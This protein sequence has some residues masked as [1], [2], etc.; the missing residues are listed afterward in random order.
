MNWISIT[1]ATAVTG[2]TERTIRRWFKSHKNDH[3]ATKKI[4]GKI[5]L[6][7]TI[8]HADYPPVMGR[9]NA[10]EEEK[11]QKE[12]LQIATNAKSIESIT[13]QLEAKDKQIDRLISHRNW[14]ILV[15]FSIFFFAALL[16]GIGVFMIFKGYKTELE[17]TKER[18]L[19][20]KS[21]AFENKISGQ[22][23]IIENLE[24]A[25]TT[26][27]QELAEKDR[28]ISELYND[29]KAQNKKLLEL[30]ESFQTKSVKPES[31]ENNSVNEAED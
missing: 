22:K 15:L 20:L 19:E 28:L 9:Q 27:R 25:N 24:K 17:N 18:E 30:T 2:K 16:I 4:G 6:N 14:F 31:I 21:E 26:Q 3:L 1:E 23:V 12:A 8:L 7:A 10:G 29:T 11:H 5:Y 13:V